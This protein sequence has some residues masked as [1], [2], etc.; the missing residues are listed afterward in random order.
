VM[1]RLARGRKR[2]QQLLTNQKY[3]EVQS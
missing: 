1:S 2:L 3:V